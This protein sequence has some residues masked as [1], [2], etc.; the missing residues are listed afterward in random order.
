MKIR[1]T[2]PK[3]PHSDDKEKES[4][5]ESELNETELKEFYSGCQY[6]Y[7]T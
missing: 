5:A 7:P 2:T 3:Y 4:V 6:R 1:F